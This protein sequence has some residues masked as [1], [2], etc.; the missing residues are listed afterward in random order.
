M[1]MSHE[2]GIKFSEWF[3]PP[4]L[5]VDLVGSL[6]HRESAWQLGTFR[7][8]CVGVRTASAGAGKLPLGLA[9]GLGTAGRA[10]HSVK[11]QTE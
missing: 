6:V 10:G 3:D 9:G 11:P 7:L 2:A 5:G 8:R 4:S 1:K